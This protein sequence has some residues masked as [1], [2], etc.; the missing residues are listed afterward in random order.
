MVSTPGTAKPSPGRDGPASGQA[1]VGRDVGVPFALGAVIVVRREDL[2]AI[3][4]FAAIR[5]YLADDYQLGCRI[6][7]QGKRIVVSPYVVETVLGP[8]SLEAVW[9]RHVRWSRTVRFSRGTGHR[10]FWWT[11]GTLWSLLL[12]A[13]SSEAPPPSSSA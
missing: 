7:A 9:E 13:S 10:W 8:E 4:G 6:S 2:D 11:F 1:L 3:G 5:P 12:L